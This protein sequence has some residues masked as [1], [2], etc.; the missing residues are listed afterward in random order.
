MTHKSPEKFK[1]RFYFFIGYL[2]YCNIFCSL[3][4]SYPRDKCVIDTI[5]SIF[6]R[7]RSSQKAALV[8]RTKYGYLE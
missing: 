8:V 6:T 2:L 3:R 1:V 7:S 4:F 5:L